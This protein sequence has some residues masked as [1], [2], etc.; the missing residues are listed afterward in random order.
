MHCGST[1]TSHVDSAGGSDRVGESE[2]LSVLTDDAGEGGLHC[3]SSLDVLQR[4]SSDST[5]VD[6]R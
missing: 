2:A 5:A 3:P 6:V 1:S 4:L